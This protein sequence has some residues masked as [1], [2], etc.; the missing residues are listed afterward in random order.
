MEAID[1]VQCG[2][3]PSHTDLD[4]R[5]KRCRECE[6]GLK[7]KCVVCDQFVSYSNAAKHLKRCRGGSNCDEEVKVRRVAYVAAEWD[8]SKG[9]MPY[10]PP[11][12]TPPRSPTTLANK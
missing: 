12:L 4:L 10:M 11:T 2:A 9:R 1:L 5:G 8:V 7:K 3:D 6:C